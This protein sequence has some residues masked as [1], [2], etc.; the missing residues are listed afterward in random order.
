MKVFMLLLIEFTNLKPLIL[1][2]IDGS[3]KSY[4]K[5]TP[6]FII[7]FSYFIMKI[8]LWKVH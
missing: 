7:E 6:L 5:N 2:K 4:C 1:E 8:L 3:G